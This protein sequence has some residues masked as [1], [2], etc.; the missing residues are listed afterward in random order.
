[1]LGDRRDSRKHS[2]LA[3]VYRRRQAVTGAGAGENEDLFISPWRRVVGGRSMRQVMFH[4]LDA[5]FNDADR[6]QRL[7]SLICLALLVRAIDEGSLEGLLRAAHQ[8]R[9]PLIIA[10]DRVAL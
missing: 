8:I 1:M 7:H 2:A 10:L 3:D 9:R 5:L 4:R 6:G